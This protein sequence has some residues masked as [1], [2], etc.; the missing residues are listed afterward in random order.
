[1]ETGDSTPSF[2]TWSTLGVYPLAV[3]SSKKWS[4]S[5]LS[6]SG[7]AACW[8]DDGSSIYNMDKCNDLPNNHQ[9]RNRFNNRGGRGRRNAGRQHGNNPPGEPCDV[10][11]DQ[12]FFIPK[13][14][15]HGEPHLVE[16][17]R[18][19]SGPVLGLLLSLSFN[20]RS[21]QV[22]VYS[23]EDERLREL[24]YTILVD[25]GGVAIQGPRESTY[26]RLQD[27]VDFATI[28]GALVSD[29]QSASQ[30]FEGMTIKEKLREARYATTRWTQVVRDRAQ[31]ARPVAAPAPAA[32]RDVEDIL[33]GKLIDAGYQVD[34]ATSLEAMKRLWCLVRHTGRLGEA[35]G[36]G[37]TYAAALTPEEVE[38][39][40]GHSAYPVGL[41]AVA[42][43]VK[44]GLMRYWAQTLPGRLLGYSDSYTM[45]VG[46]DALMHSA[47]QALNDRGFDEPI[48]RGGGVLVLRLSDPAVEANDDINE[49]HASMDL[50]RLNN[51]L[52]ARATVDCYHG[53]SLCRRMTIECGRVDVTYLFAVMSHAPKYEQIDTLIR[54]TGALHCPS[55]LGSTTRNLLFTASV[56]CRINDKYAGEVPTQAGRPSFTASGPAKPL[57]QSLKSSVKALS[58]GSGLIVLIVMLS[59]VGAS[60][61]SPLGHT[62][63]V[64]SHTPSTWVTDIQL[65]A[66][67]YI[68]KVGAPPPECDRLY[69]ALSNLSNVTLPNFMY[70]NWTNTTTLNNGWLALTTLMPEKTNFVEDGLHSWKKVDLMLENLARAIGE[71]SFLSSNVNSTLWWDQHLKL[72]EPLIR[73]ARR[74]NVYSALLRE[75]WMTLYSDIATLSNILLSLKDQP[76]LKKNMKFQ[77]LLKRLPTLQA[78]KE[79]SPQSLCSSVKSAYSSISVP[80]MPSIELTLKNFWDRP[81]WET[82]SSLVNATKLSFEQHVIRVKWTQVLVT[83]LRTAVY[84]GG[85]LLILSLELMRVMTA[86]LLSLVV[87]FLT[88]L[89]IWVS[90]LNSILLSALEILVFAAWSIVQAVLFAAMGPTQ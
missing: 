70:L 90:V 49:V 65:C 82:A 73:E 14:K 43:S 9:N 79:V 55:N 52:M 21:S 42:D 35:L 7:I 38:N 44:Q 17:L 23:S 89:V 71:P 27:G 37:K 6:L 88:V 54:R 4:C 86:C 45:S 74:L 64:Q 20:P 78:L 1:M 18:S 10:F 12:E 58:I 66:D 75:R 24:L 76:Y 84:V 5:N 31:A 13:T 33:R 87:R 83:A 26:I 25:E 72:Q 53:P 15:I 56:C 16:Y 48:P 68:A 36:E 80:R 32:R 11:V 34:E 57:C 40:A 60:Q 30:A 46:T 63:S 59:L 28:A 3:Y 47:L 81:L 61:A 85:R 69:R 62:S 50:P 19:L 8:G 29:L 67:Y 2:D 22:K 77:A 41:G 39:W 51:K